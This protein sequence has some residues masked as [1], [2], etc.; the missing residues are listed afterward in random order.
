MSPP[1][2][3][4]DELSFFGKNFSP[5]LSIFCCEKL[6]GESQR[7]MKINTKGMQKDFTVVRDVIMFNWLLNFNPILILNSISDRDASAFFK[8]EPFFKI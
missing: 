7:M 5:S 1:M 6:L 4:S 3:S 8:A 2:Y